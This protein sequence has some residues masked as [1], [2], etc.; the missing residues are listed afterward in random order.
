MRPNQASTDALAEVV[1]ARGADS[2]FVAA[3]NALAAPYMGQAIVPVEG[4]DVV[5]FP[6]KDDDTLIYQMKIH[7]CSH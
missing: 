1:P 7:F 4:G 5:E 3:A 6:H 2:A